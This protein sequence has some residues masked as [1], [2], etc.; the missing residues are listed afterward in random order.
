MQGNE[1]EPRHLL[2]PPKGI[3][4]RRS[5]DM[6][7][8]DDPAVAVALRFIR[9]NARM[10]IEVVDVAEQ[11]NLSRRSLETKFTKMIGRSPALEIRRVRIEQ[12][13][14][15]LAET[16]DPITNVV[17]AAGFNSRQVF[18]NV[19]H[20]ETGMTPTAYRR[21]FQMDVLG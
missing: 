13:K 21:Q 10:P 12:A 5:T 20:R 7:A 4:A 8:V 16:T 14:R 19:F 2:L 3:V 15:P 1:I 17:F 11:A 18:S 9:E 6:L